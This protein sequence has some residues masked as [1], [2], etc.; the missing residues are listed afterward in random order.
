MKVSLKAPFKKDFSESI[1]TLAAIASKFTE[2]ELH[3]RC[4]QMNCTKFSRTTMNYGTPVKWTSCR[5][6]S[7]ENFEKSM[8]TVNGEVQI[9]VNLRIQNGLL[10]IRFVWSFW[11]FFNIIFEQLKIKYIEPCFPFS[12]VLSY[13]VSPR[14][15]T[16]LGLVSI[17][18]RSSHLKVFCKKGVLKNRTP[19]QVFT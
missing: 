10:I 7:F 13:R 17:K 16:T 8:E 2:N 6:E 3:C 15:K 9:L 5:E 1:A 4:F 11:Y 14:D 12:T 19:A 18:I